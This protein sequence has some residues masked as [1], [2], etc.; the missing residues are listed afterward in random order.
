M[1][2]LVIEEGTEGVGTMP[3]VE[4]FTFTQRGSLI[5]HKE[6]GT[7]TDSNPNWRL[8]AILP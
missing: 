5:I 4:F 8:V 1:K 7:I 2:L 6:N 3:D